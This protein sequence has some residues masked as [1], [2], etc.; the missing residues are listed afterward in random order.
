MKRRL[1][2]L[3]VVS[4]VAGVVGWL[5]WANRHEP[6]VWAVERLGGRVL[7]ETDSDGQKAASLVFTL[8]PL[9][10]ADLGQFPDLANL[11][12]PRLFL[13]GTRITDD[14]LARLRGLRHLRVLSLGSTKVTDRGVELLAGLDQL[15]LLN[16]KFCPVTDAGL[17]H[18]RG[19]H[20]LRSLN[21]Q[22][23][24]VTKAG[25]EELRRALPG[26]FV[27]LEVRDER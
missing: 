13:D 17:L 10:D 24:R 3:A 22:N 12:H 25:V 18:L 8:R 7:F 20:G 15:E 6:A 4:L 19:L 2:F 9:D 27:A 11:P 1:L 21:V 23:T 26:L 14:G 16:L 5:A